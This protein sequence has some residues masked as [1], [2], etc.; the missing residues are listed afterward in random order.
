[1]HCFSGAHPVKSN[2]SVVTVEYWPPVFEAIRGVWGT[3]AHQF[4]DLSLL[5]CRHAYTSVT[6][7]NIRFV[8]AIHRDAATYR[9]GYHVSS[10][11]DVKKQ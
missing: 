11:Q 6:T 1:V 8:L 3:V 10:K 9:A 7:V 4:P 2:G 5:V